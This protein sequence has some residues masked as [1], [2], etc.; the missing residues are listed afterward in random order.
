MLQAA[1]MHNQAK[2]ICYYAERKINLHERIKF[3]DI[4]FTCV[5]KHLHKMNKE[6]YFE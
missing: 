6:V 2:F 4:Y 5:I 1:A 3:I